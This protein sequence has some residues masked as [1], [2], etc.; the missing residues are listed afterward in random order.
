MTSND[1]ARDGSHSR[2]DSPD[3]ISDPDRPRDP[4]TG[5]LKLRNCEM[6]TAA[7]GGFLVS[8][9]RALNGLEGRR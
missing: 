9:D 4:E 3:W 1:E 7:T 2:E 8:G 5:H 6:S